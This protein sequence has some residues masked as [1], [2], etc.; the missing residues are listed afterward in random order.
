MVK[1]ISRLQA[2]SF[3]L[4]VIGAGPGGYTAAI[5]ASQLGMKVAVVERRETA[6]G[7]C[8]NEGCIPSKALLDSSELYAL[9]GS[10]FAGHG[11]V[12]EGHRLDLAAMMARKNEVVKKLTDGIG[13][14]FRK[15]RIQSLQGTGKPAGARRDGLQVVSVTT[16]EAPAIPRL[17]TAR[18]V[19]LAAGSRP[20][21]LPSLPFDGHTVVSSREALSF[22]SVP[23]HLAVVGGGCIGLELGSVWNRLGA[24]V[25]VVE[26]LPSI[27]PNADRQISDALLKAL[28]RQGM[29]FLLESG[30]TG[31]DISEGKARLTVTTGGTEEELVCDRVLV[32][33]G[34]VPDTSGLGLQELGVLTDEK[35]GIVVD[36]DF[37]T[38]APGIFA[39]GDLVRG[40]LLAHKA[41]EEG[42]VFAERLA[43]Q[44]SVVEYEFIPAVTYTHPETAS[45]GKTEEQL[46]DEGIRYSVGRSPFSA[47]GRAR[48]LDDTD[49]FVKI[50]AHG[51]T[52][53]VMGVHII[54]PR[55]SELVAEAVTVMTYGGGIEDIAM[56]IHAHPTFSETMK[57]AAL[58]AAGR[59]VHA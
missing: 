41:M 7:V 13:F 10:A 51:E 43:G 11:I 8:L 3:D 56:T 40:P 26:T 14:L 9:A 47:C 42:V 25:T 34:R 48:C 58:D 12:I 37:M 2:D 1:D 29:R 22:A 4:I 59:A 54:G 24:R 27:L 53:K 50:L 35:G 52:G 30:V 23:E 31:C 20:V 49:G 36:D 55:A 18:R 21:E 28:K 44:A 17:L 39:V 57:E 5:R 38:S 45:T 46:R 33:V 6:G 15:N 32:A 16:P 19:L